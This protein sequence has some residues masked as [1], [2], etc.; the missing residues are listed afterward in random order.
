MLATASVFSGALGDNLMR[1][2]F[3]MEAKRLVS[4]PLIRRP[5]WG[6]GF[7]VGV[8]VASLFKFFALKMANVTL[9]VP[10][11]AAHVVFAVV[12]S[13]ILCGE[14]LYWYDIV[15]TVLVSAG[16][17]VTVVS[18]NHEIKHW[19][20]KEL[21]SLNE[22]AVFWVFLAI[23]VAV[24]GALLM[25]S[26]SKYAGRPKLNQ[27]SMSCAAG[28][29]GGICVVLEKATMDIVIVEAVQEGHWEVFRHEWT[30]TILVALILT[31]TARFVA[32]C[33]ALS[34]FSA[35]SVVPALQGAM[36]TTGM[37]LGAAY[38]QDYKAWDATNYFL[39]SLGMVLC[40]CGILLPLVLA[41]RHARD[42][43]NKAAYEVRSAI[44]VDR[45]ESIEVE[46]SASTP[47]G[48]ML[49]ERKR[50]EASG[51]QLASESTTAENTVAP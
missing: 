16:I 36:V 3:T 31:V 49:A 39:L 15:G 29:I 2:S 28:V 40:C 9:V 4:R 10:F 13:H 11:S 41:P 19:K 33:M 37:F 21:M 7:F 18:A 20:I 34:K 14:R 45:G 48:R 17:L 42:P 27:F 32:L 6:L 35:K 22:N 47:M 50:L 26:R 1:L 44:S 8:I 38:F 43:L 51:F 25:G 46:A 12:F 23:A 5:I 24:L 30:W